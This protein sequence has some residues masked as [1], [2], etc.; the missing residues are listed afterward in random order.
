MNKRKWRKT[1]QSQAAQGRAAWWFIGHAHPHSAVNDPW[2]I[3]HNTAIA[4]GKSQAEA[5]QIADDAAMEAKR[6]ER[7]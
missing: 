5:D 3:A 2:Q 7:N 6:D 1:A 4:A